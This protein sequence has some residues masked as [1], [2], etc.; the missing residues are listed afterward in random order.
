MVQFNR[1]PGCGFSCCKTRISKNG[2]LGM[3]RE[4]YTVNLKY[5]GCYWRTSFEPTSRIWTF[6]FDRY[7]ARQNNK[8]KFR[9]FSFI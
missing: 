7:S 1:R 8:C 3:K 6:V 5:L 4:N 9:I 2:N